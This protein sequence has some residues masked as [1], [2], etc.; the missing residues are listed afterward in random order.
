MGADERGDNGWIPGLG[1]QA[2]PGDADRTQ[3]DPAVN[4]QADPASGGGRPGG[5]PQT[6]GAR[7]GPAPA[8][9]RPTVY[10]VP[11]SGSPGAGHS[12]QSSYPAAPGHPGPPGYAG[13]PGSPGQSGY[14]GQ[15]GPHAAANAP[16]LLPDG[17]YGWADPGHEPARPEFP[18]VAPAAGARPRILDAEPPRPRKSR[19]WLI[20]VVVVT[21]L[22]AGAAGA[23]FGIPQVGV[24]LGLRPSPREL[25]TQTGTGFLNDWQAGN[26]AGMQARV[27]DKRDDMNRV[28]GGMAQRLHL[29]KVVV[30]P[31]LLDAAGT[32]LPYD[33]TVTLQG[34]GDVSWKS[35]VHL[36]EQTGEWRVRFTADTVYPG[37]ANGQ[38]LE[39]SETPGERGKVVD[40]NGRPLSDDPDLS[41]NVL[42][43]V[44]N[45]VGATGLERA[46]ND[47]LQG[48]AT[49]RLQITDVA[50]KQPVQVLQEWAPAAGATMTT[51]F[52]LDMQQAAGRALSGVKSRAALVAIDT[53]TGEVRAMASHPTSGL[54]AAFSS[55]YPPGSTFKIITATAALMNGMTPDSKIACPTTLSVGGRTFKNAE[56]APNS[57]PSLTDAFAE[58][59]NTAFINIGK[60]LPSG[61]LEKAAGLYGF[62]S[63]KPPLPISS[64]G[65]RIPAPKDSVEAA[66]DAIGQGK[67]EASPLQMASVAAGVA[68][69][70]WH[71]P[72]LLPDCVD[73]ASNPIPVA[74]S[75]QPQMRAVVTSGTG[76]AVSG[77]P[78]DPVHGKTGTAEFGNGDPPKTHAWFVGWQGDIA[79]AVFVEEGE[80]GGTVAAPIAAK[81]L[82]SIR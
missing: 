53:Q 60:S 5:Q 49:S 2:G 66:A 63:G 59:C 48:R 79:F 77:V 30:K 11:Q 7:P 18:D 39:L 55:Y 67:V 13:Q 14:P 36:I 78:G 58:S 9:R 50:L 82:A 80:F 51:T 68:S 16:Q 52:D 6:S 57:T 41:V 4:P 10:P 65:G 1:P 26:Y 74:A 56:K 44:K 47:K 17:T 33:A 19:R 23:A 3:V 38:R 46:F 31:G 70:T 61:A 42:G 81:F 25:A 54:A 37:M 32:S 20:A 73:C 43:A 62:N 8:L 75:L 40:R 71:Q 15:P 27:A 45:G 22:I 35:T 72:H 76:T 28:F 69:G 21:L 29:A 12:P 34:L 64:V 24:A